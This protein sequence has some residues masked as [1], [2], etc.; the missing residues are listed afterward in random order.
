ML[1]A[2]SRSSVAKRRF[3]RCDNCHWIDRESEAGPSPH[4]WNRNPE[5]DGIQHRLERE[6]A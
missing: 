6:F 3:M 4:Y 5:A 2:T 1:F